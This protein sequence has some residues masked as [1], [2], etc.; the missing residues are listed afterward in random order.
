M[1]LT[2]IL[3]YTKQIFCVYTCIHACM[4]VYVHQYIDW[5]AFIHGSILAQTGGPH[6]VV[7]LFQSPPYFLRQSHTKPEVQNSAR[8]ASQQILNAFS[9][10]SSELQAYTIIP[11][12]KVRAKDIYSCS[13][14]CVASTLS[15]ESTFQ[16]LRTKLYPQK[17][18]LV[19]LF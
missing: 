19:T 4:Y 13:Q 9:H 14:A 11:G 12:F 16:V 10:P 8:S 15:N 2:T 1:Y 6:W 7:L 5:H 18:T 17:T 3:E